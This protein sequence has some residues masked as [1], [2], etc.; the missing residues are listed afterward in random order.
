MSRAR[1]VNKANTRF[2]DRWRPPTG[3]LDPVE[4]GRTLQALALYLETPEGQY[5]FENDPQFS[6]ILLEMEVRCQRVA[7][8]I[9]WF[10]TGHR[11]AERYPMTP[12]EFWAHV[13]SQDF[14]CAICRAPFDPDNDTKMLVDHN[15]DTGEVRGILC[16]ACNTGLGMLKDSPDVLEAALEYLETRGC[17]GPNALAGDQ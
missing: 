8:T 17:Y 10:T 1:V 4:L 13:W 6:G 2:P 12:E 5:R 16:G 9:Q 3:D 14:A 11:A 15:H 7:R